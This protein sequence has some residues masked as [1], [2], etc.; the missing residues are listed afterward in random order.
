M[1]RSCAELIYIIFWSCIVIIGAIRIKKYGV[2]NIKLNL[3]KEI[4]LYKSSCLKLLSVIKRVTNRLVIPSLKL[5]LILMF[6]IAMIIYIFLSK[7]YSF[8][9]IA[10]LI[11]LTIIFYYVMR[12]VNYFDYILK[13][14]RKVFDGDFSVK[15]QEKGDKDLIKLAHNINL[16]KCKYEEVLEERLKDE[17]MKT[18]IVLNISNNLKLPIDSI[19]NYIELYKNENTLENEKNQYL[20]IIFSKA[21]KL[22][23]LITNLFEV[24]KLNSGQIEVFKEEIDIAALIYQVIGE[25]TFEYAYKNIKF[26]V[27]SFKEEVYIEADGE[28]FSKLISILVLNAFKYS[29][30]NSRIYIEIEQKNDK[31]SISMK[32]VANYELS[33]N[34]KYKSSGFGLVIASKIAELHGGSIEVQR[35]VDLFKVYLI[36]DAK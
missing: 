6:F 29:I 30:E 35:E 27:N 20:D 25:A 22:K 19:K 3:E 24:S 28:K 4:K 13:N 17:K 9:I 14:S 16:I 33:E 15:L 8:Y 2:E 36:V 23:E 18:E 12:K 7:R 31:I 1:Y 26:I 5:R 21:N 10:F 34:S 11:Y 32:N